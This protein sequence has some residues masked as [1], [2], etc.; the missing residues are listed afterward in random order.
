MEEKTMVDE[1]FRFRFFQDQRKS[2]HR[3]WRSPQ[4]RNV[5]M[6]RFRIFGARQFKLFGLCIGPGDSS[7]GQYRFWDSHA[8][9]LK[10]RVGF[11]PYNLHISTH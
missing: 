7:T 3:M 4:I 9:F 6:L 10:I 11:C 8:A 2:L 5:D 1:I